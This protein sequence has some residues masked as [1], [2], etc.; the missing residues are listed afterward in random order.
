LKQVA[1]LFVFNP[2]LFAVLDVLILA[3]TAPH[4]IGAPGCY[5]VLRCT[6]HIQKSRPTEA[7]LQ[8]RDLG[9]YFFTSDHERNENYE[10]ADARHSFPA[11]SNIRNR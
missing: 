8:F 2:Q 1:D 9:L 6:E 5:A 4:K 3:T 10:F 7:L 11:E